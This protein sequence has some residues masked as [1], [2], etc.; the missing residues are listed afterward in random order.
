M[1]FTDAY[2]SAVEAKQVAQQNKLKAETEAEQKVIEA[3]ANAEVAREKAQ[4][5]ADA[6]KIKA[7]AEAEANQK[8]AGSITD[9]VLDYKYHEVW[10]GELPM[11]SGDGS[12]VVI[13]SDLIPNNE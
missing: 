3:K 1:D 4:G 8:L 11:V 9:K 13:P 10:N 7:N 12:A 2:T 6:I 5:E